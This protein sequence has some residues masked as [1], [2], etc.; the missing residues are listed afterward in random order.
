ME[1]DSGDDA[2]LCTPTRNDC[3]LT[4]PPLVKAEPVQRDPSG[5][6]EAAVVL[7]LLDQLHDTFVEELKGF[8]VAFD[9]CIV[10]GLSAETKALMRRVGFKHLKYRME[11]GGWINETPKRKRSD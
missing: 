6:F 10:D 2:L 11:T 4:P 1:D 3:L 9:E 5:L 8:D 7:A